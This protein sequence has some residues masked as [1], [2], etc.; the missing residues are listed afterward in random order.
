MLKNQYLSIHISISHYLSPMVVVFFF[1]Y[2]F[3]F[4]HVSHILRVLP[5]TQH[6]SC[7]LVDVEV[8][9]V[10]LLS[11]PPLISAWLS[12]LCCSSDW[13][14]GR[15]E[16]IWFCWSMMSDDDGARNT[17]TDRPDTTATTRRRKETVHC[18]HIHTQSHT[19][20]HNRKQQIYIL[21]AGR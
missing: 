15:T 11:P 9:V 19:H 8:K 13:L 12:S 7:V 4:K 10:F 21:P 5:T 2:F 17:T 3:Y 14:L 6:Y 16:I 18:T 20:T 1:Y